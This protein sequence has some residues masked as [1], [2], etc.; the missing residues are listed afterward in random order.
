MALNKKDLEQAILIEK[1]KGMSDIQIGKKYGVTYKYIEKVITKTKGINISRL[2]GKKVIKRLHPTDFKEEKTTV[3]S[4][5]HRGDW[6]THSGDYRGNW[7]PYIPRNVILKYSQPGDLVLDYFCGAGTTAIEC[8][9]LG[10]RCIALDIND[11]AIELAKK[12]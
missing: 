8:K 11:K 12:N 4:F 5:K 10:R 6:A 1:E 7:S 3:W 9:L 2:N